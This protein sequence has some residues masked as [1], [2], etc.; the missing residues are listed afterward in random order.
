M[1]YDRWWKSVYYKQ[2][3]YNPV[4]INGG[5][6]KFKGGSLKCIYDDFIKNPFGN[7]FLETSQPRSLADYIVG[8]ESE[9]SEYS[10]YRP[11]MSFELKRTLEKMS[12]KLG[13]RKLINENN[14]IEES[15][16][17]EMEEDE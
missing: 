8:L 13:I 5:W 7:T 12:H 6:Y 1:T 16:D 14:E 3:G 2:K 11:A 17:F 9:E 15:F 10:G 4:S